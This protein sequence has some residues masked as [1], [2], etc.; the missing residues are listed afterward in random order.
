M[1]R[2]RWFHETRQKYITAHLFGY[3]LPVLLKLH[4]SEI[5]QVTLPAS[6]ANLYLRSVCSRSHW[7]P[8][9][10]GNDAVAHKRAHAHRAVIRSRD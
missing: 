10:I 2:D 1:L 8:R 7:K 4:W 3:L 6:I 5:G 9:E